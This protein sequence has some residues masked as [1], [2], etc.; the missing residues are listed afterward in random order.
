MRIA[1][2]ASVH[3][4]FSHARAGYVVLASLL[5]EL[6]LA[7]HEVRLFTMG[8]A[9]Q[10]DAGTLGRLGKVRV[11]HAGDLTDQTRPEFPL[12]GLRSDLRTL[13]KAYLPDQDDDY[14]K[15]DDPAAA[16]SRVAEGADAVILFWDTWFEL[17]I[18]ALGMVPVI[19]YLA[20]PRTASP[21][22]ANEAHPLQG[23]AGVKQRVLLR[24]LRNQEARHLR[25]LRG[26]SAA[27]NICA[28]DAAYYSEHGVP[29]DYLP[30]TWPDFFGDGWRERRDG[31]EAGRAKVGVLANIGSVNATGN[32]FGL[33]YLTREVLPSL[34]AGLAERIEVNV[35]GGGKLDAALAGELE[36]RGVRIRGFVDDIDAEV[37]ANRA[38]LL[39]N[40]AGPY[41][42]GYT[43]V[44]Y[45]FSSGACLVA[46]RRLADSMPE[47]KHGE[48]ALLGSSGAEIAELL[49]QV[50]SDPA[51]ARRL[52]EGGRRTYEQA[53]RPEII[54]R[55][56]LER[57]AA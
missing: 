56:L 9:N 4:S 28:L 44:I 37:L 54:A 46:H 16:A 26:L 15:F 21:I 18:P 49:R 42:G 10:P 23:M 32:G 1:V 11:T 3:P 20:R 53:Y 50:V 43:R 6:G 48:N 35:C 45:A 52:G 40:N 47:V 34:A 22:S 14:P 24:I 5:E 2:L 17:L 36:A 30:N 13:R 55:G 19:G 38:F 41:T 12:A 33:E 51:L 39:L 29:C 27:A 7:G 31:A 57:M 25:R 8:C